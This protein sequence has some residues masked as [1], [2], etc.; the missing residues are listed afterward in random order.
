MMFSGQVFAAS[1]IDM[2][3][4]TTIN[5]ELKASENISTIED[6][7]KDLFIKYLKEYAGVDA[8]QIPQDAQ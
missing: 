2:N 7:Y 4:S 8:S 5:Y 6:E 3:Y 1:N